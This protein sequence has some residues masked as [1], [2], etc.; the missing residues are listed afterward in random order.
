M[1]KSN[2]EE[3]RNTHKSV[4]ITLWFYWIALLVHSIYIASTTGQLGISFIIFNAG[5]VIFFTS[6]RIYRN[7]RK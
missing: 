1:K 3:R 4:V 6:N 5:M 2:D 7:K